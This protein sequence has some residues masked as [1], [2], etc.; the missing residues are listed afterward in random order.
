MALKLIGGLGAVGSASALV[1]E[2][3][4]LSLLQSYKINDDWRDIT[5]E[6]GQVFM[7]SPARETHEILGRYLLMLGGQEDKPGAHEAASRMMLLRAA[8]TANLGD[9]PTAFKWYRAARK[10][11][12]ES[13]DLQL[14][15]WVRGREATRRGYE[16]ASP[17]AVL[18]LTA[19]L[20]CTEGHLARAQAFAR[21]GERRG[22]L[23]ALADAARAYPK[24]DQSEGTVYGFQ[25]WRY[26]L[27]E[28]YVWALLG[29]VERA[30]GQAST[31]PLPDRLQRF[32]AQK[33]LT[34]AVALNRAGSKIEAQMTAQRIMDRHPADQSSMILKTMAT[35]ANQ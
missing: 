3:L 11:A 6:I 21:I 28:A 16:G 17:E 34:H 13:G 29:E 14:I 1:S 26:A 20:D 9:L 10:I 5:E 4:R 23:E 2:A 15:T 25:P 32:V 7:T 35:E 30:H 12:D 24:T 31:V 22:A 27:C 33:E 18:N 19:G 8:T